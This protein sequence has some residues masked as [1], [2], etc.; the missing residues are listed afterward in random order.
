VLRLLPATRF[1]GER[2]LHQNLSWTRWRVCRA[3]LQP[4]LLPLVLS[5]WYSQ[6]NSLLLPLPG[7][8]PRVHTAT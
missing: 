8:P 2:V 1:K 7:P 5:G 6:T 3:T 4:L